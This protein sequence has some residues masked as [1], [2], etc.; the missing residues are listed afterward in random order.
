MQ[1]IQ[2][3]PD[4]ELAN[5]LQSEAERNKVSVSTFVTD[6]LKEY[7]GLSSRENKTALTRRVIQEVEDYLEQLSETDGNTFDLN[8]ASATYR[9]IPMT[10]G[11][12]PNPT[13]A[14]IG[15]SFGA[16]VGKPPFQCIRKCIRNGKQV[17]SENN[18]LVYEKIRII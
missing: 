12:K 3:Y 10:C 9:K 1:R 13:R 17:L 2:F 16:K 5:V 14:S 18:A 7:Y 4:K 8:K 6:L 15:R 11:G